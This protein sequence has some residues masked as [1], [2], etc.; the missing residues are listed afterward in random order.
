MPKDN[1]SLPIIEL[2]I[3]ATTSHEALSFMVGLLGYNQIWLEPMDEKL[4]AFRTP[5]GIYCYK[6]MPLGI[7]HVGV[8]YQHDPWEC[9]VQCWQSG[10]K[11]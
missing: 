5:K 1:F 11:V 2:M 10:G 3:E 6:V 8:I 7:K 4:I 9:W